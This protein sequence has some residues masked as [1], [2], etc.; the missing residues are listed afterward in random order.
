MTELQKYLKGL[1]SSIKSDYLQNISIDLAE[2]FTD[3]MLEDGI[4]KDIP[5]IGTIV[6]LSKFGI[7]VRDRLFLKKVITFLLELKDIPSIERIKMISEIDNDPK[8]KIKIGEK[9]LYILDKCEDHEKAKLTSI[10]FK[11]Y[12]REQINY[13]DF[14]KSAKVIENCFME[15]LK[16]FIQSD[17]TDLSI[18][19]SAEYLNCG[20]F[21]IEQ[22]STKIEE[23]REP[24]IEEIS[25]YKIINGNL[26]STITSIGKIIRHELKDYYR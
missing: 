24:G 4:L 10:L 7:N 12:I 22:L 20:L 13:A 8:Y 15:D 17:W 1:E 21:E 3:S 6:G 25:K 5:I 11:S 9:L 18:E 2:T 19:E 26:K 16:N 14:L 23:T